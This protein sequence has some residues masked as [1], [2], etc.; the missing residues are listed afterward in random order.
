MGRALA[1]VL[2]AAEDSRVR[3][4]HGLMG[5]YSRHWFLLHDSGSSLELLDS[6]E[7]G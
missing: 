4:L 1:W 7:H 5:K 2:G 3:Y 6:Q